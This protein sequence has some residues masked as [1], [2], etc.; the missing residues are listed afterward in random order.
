L[1][2]VTT[3]LTGARLRWWRARMFGPRARDV[4]FVLVVLGINLGYAASR[5]GKSADDWVFVL[6][7]VGIASAVALWWRRGHPVAVTLI[8]LA[9]AAVTGIPAALTVALFTLAIRRRDRVLWAITGLCFVVDVIRTA[10]TDDQMNLVSIILTSTLYFA[11]VLAFGAYVG[12]RR[13]LVTSLRERAETA[14]AERELRADQARL[15]ERHR[16]AQEM[17]DVLAHKVSLIALHAGAL[18]VNAGAGPEQVERTAALVRTTARE[19]LDDLRRVLGVLRTDDS[20]DGSD[21][22][23]APGIAEIGR[24]V[25]ASRVAGVEVDLRC[26]ITGTPPAVLG[27]T[28]YRIVQE[29]LTN[30]H[31]HARAAS[32]VVLLSGAEGAGLD[33]EVRNQLPV[34]AATLLP[35]SGMG[36]VG[37]SERVELVG[38]DL[39]WGRAR[40]GGWRVQAHLP[41]AAPAPS[42]SSASDTH[43]PA[44]GAGA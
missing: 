17:H 22:A 28:A 39:E 42:A 18:E 5:D 31:K 33:V 6:V 16:I 15:G 34:S 23:P 36:L 44:E 37:L 3:L 2:A 26:E 1:E 41:W 24:L 19:A 43:G 4:L 14:E 10:F 20:S 11:A 29:S 13:D 27:R 21:L 9:C 35:G 7:V 30:V 12:A 40:D 8:S 32:T 38:G 25:E